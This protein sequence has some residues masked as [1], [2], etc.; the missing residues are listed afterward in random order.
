MREGAVGGGE[1]RSAVARRFLHAGGLEDMLGDEIFPGLAGHLLDQ[2]AGDHVEDVVI[3]IAAA[4]AGRGLDVAQPLHRLAAA[5]VRTGDEE[6]IAG[7]KPQAAAMDEQVAH[8]H[9]RSEEHTSE[10][11]SLMRISYAVFCLKKKKKEKST[12]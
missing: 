2:L 9:L 11:Q 8:G 6:E 12:L 1:T 4:E 5:P 10:P 3:G 7:A